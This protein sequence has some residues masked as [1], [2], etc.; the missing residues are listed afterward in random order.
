MPVY[1]YECM[2]CRKRCEVIQRFDDPPIET[3]EQC[4]GQMQKLISNTS[5]VLKGNGWYVTDYVRNAETKKEQSN[6]NKQTHEKGEA[7]GEAA[8]TE[9]K[10][11]NVGE[12]AKTE[13]NKE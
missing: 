3:C 11:P 1:E 9:T 4:G 13:G 5:F 8:S 7:K 10:Q 6:G 2:S 12:V